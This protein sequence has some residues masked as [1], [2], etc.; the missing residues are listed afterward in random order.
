VINA[1]ALVCKYGNGEQFNQ[2]RSLSVN[3]GLTPTVSSSGHRIQ[4]H[5]ISKRG[6]RYCRKQLIHGARILL[7]ICENRENDTLCRWAARL[8]Q[9]KGTKVAVVAFE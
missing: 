2:A 3:L 6:D 9:R 5:N 1:T 4:I 8:K 7:M